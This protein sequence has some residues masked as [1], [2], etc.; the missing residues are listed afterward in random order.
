MKKTKQPYEFLARWNADTGE[1][2]GAHIGF[3]VTVID[4]DGSVLS[5]QQLPVEPV[6]LAGET[7]FPIADVL[8]KIHIDAI[9]RCDLLEQ[10]NASM[11]VAIKE[12]DAA[13][14]ALRAEIAPQ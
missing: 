10:E 5:R 2:Q 1:F 8:G 3:I 11:A 12:K 6:S 4:D 13:I 9:A 14:E 7:G